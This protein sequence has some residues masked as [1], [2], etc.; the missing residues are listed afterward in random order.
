VDVEA[1]LATLEGSL[2]DEHWKIA[3]AMLEK[4]T[5]QEAVVYG[6]RTKERLEF[7]QG[8]K[9]DPE[10]KKFERPKSLRPA[11]RQE[12]ETRQTDNAYDSFRNRLRGGARPGPTSTAPGREVT[13]PQRGQQQSVAWLKTS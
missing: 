6:G 13:A 7:L 9:N 4:M 8:L 3:D 5:D 11:Q 1:E 10:F 2:T 12:P